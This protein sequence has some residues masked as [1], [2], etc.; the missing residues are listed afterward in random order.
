VTRGQ[1]AATKCV[2]VGKKH[3]G[4]KFKEEEREREKKR[5]YLPGEEVKNYWERSTTKVEVLRVRV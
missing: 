1:S 3:R 4:S 2:E 5:K